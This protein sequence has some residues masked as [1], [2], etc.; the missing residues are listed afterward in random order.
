MLA[1]ASGDA[2]WTDHRFPFPFEMENTKQVEDAMMEN[3]EKLLGGKKPAAA[4]AKPPPA[5]RTLTDDSKW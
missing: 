2:G 4:K 1:I 5:P 3:V